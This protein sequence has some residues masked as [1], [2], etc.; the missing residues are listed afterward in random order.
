MGGLYCKGAF[1]SHNLKE[2]NIFTMPLDLNWL[3][4]T[5]KF[6]KMAFAFWNSLLNTWRNAH[7]GLVEAKPKGIE[8]MLRLLLFGDCSML[9]PC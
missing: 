6:R 5:S 8:K 4:A 9:Y 3:F 2:R 1:R 7:N